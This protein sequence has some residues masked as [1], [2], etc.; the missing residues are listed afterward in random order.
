MDSSY[1]GSSITVSSALDNTRNSKQPALNFHIQ[2]HLP[3]EMDYCAHS[4]AFYLL[5]RKNLM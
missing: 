2:T 3:G 5:F 1:L 4:M